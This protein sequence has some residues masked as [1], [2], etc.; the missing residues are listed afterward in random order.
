MYKT[1]KIS[2]SIWDNYLSGIERRMS[3]TVV[4]VDIE[5]D[6]EKTLADYPPADNFS[7]PIPCDEPN[8][9]ITPDPTGI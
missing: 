8:D 4:I 3:S 9:D 5:D 7:D 6:K 1:K 2:I